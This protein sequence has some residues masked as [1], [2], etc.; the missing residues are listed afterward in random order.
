MQRLLRNQQNRLFPGHVFQLN[1][2]LTVVHQYIPSTP[3]AVAD[4]WI[5][6]GAKIEPT[7]WLGMAHFL[8]HMIFKGT[9]NIYPGEFDYKIENTG[10]I[11]NAATSH[12]YVHYFLTTAA[13][14][15]SETLPYLA[16]ILLQAEIPE[17][18]FYREREVVLEEIR[19]CYDDPD[20]IG[21][22]SLCEIIY[23]SHPYGRGILGE[24][25]LLR[26][27]TPN[28]MRC[29]HK[30]HYQPENMTVV[31]TGGIKQE[32]ALSLVAECFLDFSIRSECPPH[33]IVAE[34]PIIG[35][36]RQEIALPR[37]EHA[38]LGMGWLGPNVEQLADALALEMLSIILAGGRS[39]R[40]ISKL[41]EEQQLVLDITSEYS[42]QQDSSLFTISAW[43]EPEY[44]FKVEAAICAE[45]ERLQN[46]LITEA[47]L[48]KNKRILRND[49]LFSTETPAQLAGLYG[50]YQTIA[51]AELSLSYPI[52]IE[53]LTV[54]DL[55]RVAR[56][57]LSVEH[58]AISTLYPDS[59][60]TNNNLHAN[61]NIELSARNN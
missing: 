38:R 60:I 11:T 42:L 58:Y 46:E 41:R 61:S 50:Y 29:F 55:Q 6:A 48:A 43:L 40:L 24:E 27:H 30:T 7:S 33:H 20:W 19:Q 26:Q 18:E 31:I 53:R 49:Y 59:L 57:Y 45:I 12:D 25:E 22:Q 2:G 37:I 34:A 52:I 10:G 39:S 32:Q 44:I 13:T 47:E 23:E 28:Q 56:Q 21:F 17:V 15:L 8:E 5:N 54:Q 35:V 51:S 16:E 14:H 4:V 3:V 36:R 9:K 1:N